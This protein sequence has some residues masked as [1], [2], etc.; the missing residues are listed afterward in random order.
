MESRLWTTTPLFH[1]SITP[2]LPRAAA[3]EESSIV[4]GGRVLP[5]RYFLAPLAGYTHLAFRRA[6]REIGGIGL[7]TTDLVLG[8]YLVRGT[9]KSRR[10]VRTHPDD[11]PLSVQIFAKRTEDW[12]AAA[13]WLEERGYGGVDLNMGCPMGKINRGGGGARLLCEA[14]DAVQLVERVVAAVGIPV[15]VKMRLGWDRDS[16]TAPLLAREFEKVGAAAVTIHGRTR[17]QGFGG[18]VDL[19]GIKA[20]VDAVERMPVIGNGDVRSPQ[21][22]LRMRRITG[23]DAVAIGRGAMLD[24]WIFRRLQQICEGTPVT[25]PTPDEQ[26]AFLVRH[27]SLMAD[28]HGDYACTLFRKFAGWYGARLGIPDDLEDRLRRVERIAEFEAVVE[29]IRQRHGQ[30][31]SPIATAE[32]KVPNGPVERW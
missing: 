16:L 9:P 18:S 17:Q 2:L 22:A 23:C 14:N 28:E 4:I 31:I 21:D 12:I 6:I 32:L 27:F 25:A 1:H 10:L 8:P 7:C 13:K 24:P 15:T 29:Q 5:T 30:R 19:D 11:R 20:V 3:D 26:I